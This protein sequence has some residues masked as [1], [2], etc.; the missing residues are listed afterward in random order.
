MNV[1]VYLVPMALALGLAGLFAFLWSLKNGQY[2]DLEGAAVRILGDED[3]ADD[4]GGREKP[5]SGLRHQ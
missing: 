2:D 1:L 3:V 5:A 4:R